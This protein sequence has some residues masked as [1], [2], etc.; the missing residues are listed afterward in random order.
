MHPS[1]EAYEGACPLRRSWRGRVQGRAGDGA[2]FKSLQPRHFFHLAVTG[3]DKRPAAGGFRRGRSSVRNPE[4]S[5]PTTVAVR[6]LNAEAALS[7]PP[8]FPAF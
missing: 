8:I 3:H 5:L 2:W 4:Q 1:W 6:R 7:S